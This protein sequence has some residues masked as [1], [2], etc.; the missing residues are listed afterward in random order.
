MAQKKKSARTVKWRGKWYLFYTDHLTGQQKRVT[1]QSRGATNAE[2]RRELVNQHRSVELKQHAEVTLL[3]GIISGDVTL[4]GEIEEYVAYSVERGETRADNPDSREGLSPKSLKIIDTAMNHF[5]GWILNS[6]Y[7]NLLTKDVTPEL[8]TVYFK[9]IVRE[10][11]RGDKNGRNQKKRSASTINH[12]KRCTKACL[13]WINARRPRRF[14]DFEPLLVPMKPTRGKARA[15]IAFEPD[16][17]CSFFIEADRRGDPSRAVNVK[18]V[19]GSRKKAVHVQ[20]V[21]SVCSTPVSRLFLL[22][23]LTGCRLGE[24][25]GMK[26][27]HI[28]LRR[29]RIV[30]ESP[31]TGSIRWLPLT[32]DPAGEVGPRMAEL[33]RLW[34]SE[35]ESEYILPHGKLDAPVF[36]K[37]TWY[38]IAKAVDLNISP[39]KLRQSFTSY[40]ASMAVPAT[41]SAMWQGHSTQVAEKHY[42]AQIL[43]RK[44]GDS[45]EEAMGLD[46]ILD[47]L[48]GQND[49]GPKRARLSE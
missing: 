22:L 16:E 36:P 27:E 5:L 48:I 30:I 19:K 10:P 14:P 47:E 9:F 12:Y 32:G 29:G 37:G 17:L 46:K 39:Q 23:A 8:L 43:N 3:G 1:C 25:L 2:L 24:A 7:K 45:I 15:P 18:L 26:W 33:L 42:R 6:G 20:P 28:D 35:A 38:S 11:V 13:N 41:I 4:L 49:D 40:A 34:H 31:K 21:S 44:D